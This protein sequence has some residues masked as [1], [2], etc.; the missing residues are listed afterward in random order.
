MGEG[1][2]EQVG[3][4]GSGGTGEC[5]IGGNRWVKDRGEQVGRK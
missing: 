5:R 1:L 2:G 3:E 4:L